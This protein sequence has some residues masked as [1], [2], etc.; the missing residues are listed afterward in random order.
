MLFKIGMFAEINFIEALISRIKKN[1]SDFYF[2][3]P[4]LFECKTHPHSLITTNNLLI[5]PIK[6]PY[7]SALIPR[8]TTIPK[9]NR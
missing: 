7:I 6:P 8:P 3:T 2:T 4:I 1:E 5:T 9:Q